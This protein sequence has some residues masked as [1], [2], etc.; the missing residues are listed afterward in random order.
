VKEGKGKSLQ[1]EGEK[2][3]TGENVFAMLVGN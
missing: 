2:K 1:E 3:T